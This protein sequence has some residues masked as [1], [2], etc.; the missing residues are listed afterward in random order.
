MGKPAAR[1]SDLH[2]CPMVTALVPHMGGPIM[3]PGCPSV[4]IGGIP[5]ARMGDMAACAGPTDAIASGNPKV[6]VGGRPLARMGDPTVHGGVIVS[7]FA[8]VLVG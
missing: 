8:K 7:G 3:P 1:I 5:A 4:L 2:T 6:L